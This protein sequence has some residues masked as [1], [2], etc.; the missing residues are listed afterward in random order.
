MRIIRLEEALEKVNKKMIKLYYYFWI[1]H[2]II[3]L[4]DKLLMQIYSKYSNL[5]KELNSKSE[6]IVRIKNESELQIKVC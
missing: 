6:D 1:Q 5:H 2:Y 4:H 3:L